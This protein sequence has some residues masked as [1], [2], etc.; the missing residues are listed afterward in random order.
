MQPEQLLCWEWYD[1]LTDTEHTTS[2]SNE[3]IIRHTPKNCKW[4]LLLLFKT[5][6][7]QQ[8]ADGL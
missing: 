7:G 3:E 2:G 5:I 8:K 1:R 6:A 4:H